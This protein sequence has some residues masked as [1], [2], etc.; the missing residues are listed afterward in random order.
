VKIER[1]ELRLLKLPLVHF[2]ET[3][4]SRTYQR[5]IVLVEVISDGLSGWGEVT[6]GVRNFR[7]NQSLIEMLS[8][9]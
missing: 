6:A 5:A 1:L 4:F 3:S 7:F 9:I 2:F 8:Y